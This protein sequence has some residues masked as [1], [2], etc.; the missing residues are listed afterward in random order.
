MRTISSNFESKMAEQNLHPLRRFKYNG[1]YYTAYVDDYGVAMLNAK[2]VSAGAVTV[3]LINTDKTFNMFLSDIS[4]I[5]NTGI[6]DFALGAIGKVARAGC[7]IAGLSVAGLVSPNT[8]CNLTNIYVAIGGEWVKFFTG[9][10]DETQFYKAHLNLQLRD[11]MASML[12][13]EIG[14]FQSP[15]DYYSSS[16]NPADLTWD[17]LVTHGG[18]DSTVTT[19]NTDIDYTIWSDWKT[20]CAGLS[21][22]LEAKLEG[23]GTTIG[24]VLKKIAYLTHTL[25]FV[26]GDNKFVFYRYAP[27]AALVYTFNNSNSRNFEVHQTVEDII[28]DIT[29]YYDYD[30]AGGTWAGNVT[31]SD[32]TS[33]TDYGTVPRTEEDTQVWHATQGS[34]QEFCNREM[35]RYKDPRQ[36]CSFETGING[37]VIEPGD[38]INNDISFPGYVSAPFEIR[39]LEFNL[40]V[41]RTRIE[42]LN[43][44]FYQLGGFL[45]DD[46]YWGLLDEAYNPLF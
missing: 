8:N 37:F 15:I 28:N 36:F 21:L 32:A 24:S 25:I 31:A 23:G 19:A 26:R 45:L 13:K 30:Q 35:G 34:A 1:T 10:G 9:I 39:N 3:G 46:A 38:L 4:N 44:N 22:S 41:G 12:E 5:R 2:K 18:L 11:K 14:S 29:C 40:N 7:A 33:K 43:V 6:I 17:L 27:P 42:A 16:Y 20:D